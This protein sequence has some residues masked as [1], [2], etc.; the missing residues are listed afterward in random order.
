MGGLPGGHGALAAMGAAAL[1]LLAVPAGVGA[2][3][4]ISGA[5]GDA[6]NTAPVYVVTGGDG[7][8]RWTW[9][10]TTGDRGE[11]E[12]SP[13]E[14]ALAGRRL[15][16]GSHTLTVVQENGAG[17]G[18]PDQG[19]PPPR[20]VA[21]RTFI[22]DQ[23]PPPT[24][25]VLG[26][27]L[28]PAAAPLAVSWAGVEEGAVVTWTVARL[29]P[30]GAAVVQGP[31]ETT[32]A[33]VTISG[34]EPG[35]HEVRATQRDRAGNVSPSASLI[36]T[37]EAAAPPPPVAPAPVPP[38]S[39]AAPSASPS[40][41]TRTT[42]YATIVRLPSL[43]ARGMRP[44][45]AATIRIRRPILRWTRGPRGTTIY[46]V[47]L[48]KVVMRRDAAGARVAELRKVR[49]AFPRRTRLRTPRLARGGCYVW[50]VWPYR[51]LRFTTRPLG[52]S[53]FCVTRRAARPARR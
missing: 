36:V 41:A 5:D 33:S 12:G 29:D 30:G 15:T 13:F 53:H 11:S 47:Q 49:S 24:P 40:P 4:T 8:E 38:T 9:R 42:T 16:E 39:R 3:P 35:L 2:P 43:G 21:V 31:V 48:F 51:G 28:H 26:P 6:W 23:T 22:V 17:G 20:E 34:L 50:R 19:R 46:N 10:S 25:A 37:I 45:K 27:A 1:S 44:R 32:A 18:D 52:V 14:V 7:G